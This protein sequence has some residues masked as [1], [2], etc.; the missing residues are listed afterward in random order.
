MRCSASHDD[1]RCV[2]DLFWFVAL[3]PLSNHHVIRL[4]KK[5]R[6]VALMSSSVRPFTSTGFDTALAR[7]TVTTLSW[8]QADSRH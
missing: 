2:G 7:I 4:D 5:Y 3:K 6:T 1:R 8:V